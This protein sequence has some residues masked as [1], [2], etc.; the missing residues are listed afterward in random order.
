[1][2]AGNVFYEVISS[3]ED[4]VPWSCLLTNEITIWSRDLEKLTVA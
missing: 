3:A 1:M 2:T 4:R